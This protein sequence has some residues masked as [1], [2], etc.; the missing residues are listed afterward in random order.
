[1]KLKSFF[2]FFLAL[3]MLFPSFGFAKDSSISNIKKRGV[4]YCG[5]N[6][7]NNF[8]AYQNDDGVW[9]GFDAALCRALASAF[10]DNK[11]L[12][13]MVPLKIEDVP[14]ALQS[15]EIDVMFGEF[16]MPA[17]TEFTSNV[18]NID[19]LYDD[20]VMLLAHQREDATSLEDY[21][22]AKVCMARSSVDAYQF[23]NFVSRY[24]LAFQP[25][26]FADRSRA[27]EGFYLSRCELLVGAS[28]EL[29]GIAASKFKKKKNIELLP[30]TIGLRP[31]YL[32]V[33]K[34]SLQVG[35]AAKWIFN[36]LKLAESYNV[37]S[38]NLPTMLGQDDFSLQN[39]LGNQ[40][41]LWKKFRAYPH[42]MR[43]F[44]VEE[45]NFGE[46]FERHLGTGTDIGL[47]KPEPEHGLAA[48]KPFI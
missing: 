15:G 33:D 19:V 47:E 24:N 44:I 40:E 2:Y 32:M 45:G 39:L 8:L 5:T 20:K 3:V 27:V 18:I 35:I 41:T 14:Q 10:L 38:E 9:Q 26:Y 16:Q 7:N 28:S 21:K 25:V 34:N 12:I 13:K 4:V 30:E 11:D 48:P 29:K 31:I 6:K 22:D 23:S 42:W 37:T 36:A 46:M 17:E 43:K 1:M